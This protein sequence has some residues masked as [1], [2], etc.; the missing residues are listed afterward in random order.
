MVPATRRTVCSVPCDYCGVE[1]DPISTRWLCPHCHMKANCCDGAPLA[2]AVRRRSRT[3]PAEPAGVSS[4]SSS[5]PT[6][7]STSSPATCSPTAPWSSRATGS[8]RWCAASTRPPRRRPR[9][10]RPPLLPGLVDCHAHLVGEPDG[11][12]G[13]A[14]LLTRTG[15]QEAL[16]GVRN[17]RDTLRAGFTT[18]RDVGTFRAFVDVALRDAINA[19]WM[20]GPRMK[21]AGAYVTC[22]GGGGDITGLAPDVDAVVPPSCASAS[23]T[24]STRSPAPCA[25]CCTA[26]PT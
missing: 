3:P 25:G 8:P 7:C 24:P 1:F 10:A 13:Y 17:A 23:P 18:V 22:S 12:H 11:G 21:V 5:V 15:A 9:P 2:P 14:E 20:P 6:G 19:G 26:A 4:S 16:S